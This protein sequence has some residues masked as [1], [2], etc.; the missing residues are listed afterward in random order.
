[1]TFTGSD[2]N[3][4]RIW[5]PKGKCLNVLEGHEGMVSCLDFQDGTLYSG[6]LDATIRVWDKSG[7]NTNIINLQG[8]S[9]FIRGKTKKKVHHSHSFI[10]H[11][12][13]GL[14]GWIW[15]LSVE[16][17]S[18][19]CGGRYPKIQVCDKSTGTPTHTF[20]GHLGAV[21]TLCVDG[22]TIYSGSW[23]LSARQW[24]EKTRNWKTRLHK[25]GT[26]VG[27]DALAARYQSKKG[28]LNNS[29]NNS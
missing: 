29:D 26:A 1:M 11:D 15:D 19:Y 13:L 18:I 8:L 17:N 16:G 5:N 2:D 9:F 3:T 7:K 22:D 27:M 20:E 4:V 10:Q 14:T 6:S 25:A 24:K 12:K 21:T 28:G 23:D